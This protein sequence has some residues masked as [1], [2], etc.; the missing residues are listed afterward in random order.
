MTVRDEA[1]KPYIQARMTL[2]ARHVQ[3]AV[4]DA[5]DLRPEAT[6]NLSQV[7]YSLCR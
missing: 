3:S 7:T 5:S 6:F 4:S 2:E 1:L